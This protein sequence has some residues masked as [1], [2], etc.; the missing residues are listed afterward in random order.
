MRS[1][2]ATFTV[3]ID[4]GVR[5]GYGHPRI[6]LW[7]YAVRSTVALLIAS[8]YYHGLEGGLP[9]GGAH[10]PSSGSAET[11]RPSRPLSLPVP[12][13]VA[14]VVLLPVLPLGLLDLLLVVPLPLVLF[15]VPLGGRRF[16][17]HPL[18]SSS[19]ALGLWSFE[20]LFLLFWPHFVF[21]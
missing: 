8:L 3:H 20:F 5:E 15:L 10:P 14:P 19:S 18:S 9:T 17:P 11:C 1:I 6:C 12:L 2:S 7:A 13:A 21:C 16:R 4:C